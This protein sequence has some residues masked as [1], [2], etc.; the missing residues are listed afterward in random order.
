MKKIIMIAL[1]SQAF[2]GDL[3]AGTGY[4]YCATSKNYH[5]D[6]GYPEQIIT[7]GYSDEFDINMPS[8]IHL[9]AEAGFNLYRPN[10]LF[11]QGN[12]GPSIPVTSSWTITAGPSILYLTTPGKT[13]MG[14]NLQLK[15]TIDENT[16]FI[17]VLSGQY[18]AHDYSP[19]MSGSF[20]LKAYKTL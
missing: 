12:I 17:A 15:H 13:L 1:A 3:T 10:E 11:I 16:G 2:A 7:A 6:F 5:E 8:N 14:K 9:S 19:Q 4:M 20:T 18:A